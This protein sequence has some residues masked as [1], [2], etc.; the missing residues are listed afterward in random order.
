MHLIYLMIDILRFHV[1]I[2][3]LPGYFLS[4]LPRRDGWSLVN[5]A[6][7]YNGLMTEVLGYKTYVAQGGDWVRCPL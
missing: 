2:P 7:V 4:T 5:T 1:V 3:S 6:T